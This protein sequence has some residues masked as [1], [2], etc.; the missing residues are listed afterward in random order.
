MKR[1]N[2][3]VL[4]YAVLFS[5]AIFIQSC[6]LGEH[7]ITGDGSISIVE[8]FGTPVDTLS[9]PFRIVV[10]PTLTLSDNYQDFGLLTSSYAVT[11]D[12]PVENRI[13]V[14]SVELTLDK[15]ITL[16]NEQIGVGTNLIGEQGVTF[17]DGDYSGSFLELTVEFDQSF[18]DNVVF[19]SNRYDFIVKMS[20]DDGLDIEHTVSAY[21]KL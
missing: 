10:E 14:G 7:N 4:F 5:S 9:G 21:V 1:F 6:C 3:L 12:N 15:T 2:Q 13:D 20:T 11:C 17:V 19:D 16:N 8:G 18:M